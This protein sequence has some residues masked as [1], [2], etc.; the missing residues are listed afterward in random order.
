[1]T[2]RTTHF[3]INEQRGHKKGEG[4]ERGREKMQ[5]M[6][7]KEIVLWAVQKGKETTKVG[8]T[9]KIKMGMRKT[10]LGNIKKVSRTAQGRSTGG[11][12]AEDGNNKK[13]RTGGYMK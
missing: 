4:E 10:E 5:V 7:R 2:S 8:T 12:P 3:S 13:V 1:M 9:H 6:K 11:S